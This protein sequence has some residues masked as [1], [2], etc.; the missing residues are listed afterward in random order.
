MRAVARAS[1]ERALL[2]YG[3]AARRPIDSAAILIAS[4]MSLVIL[5]NCLFWQSR[6]LPAPVF[7][8]A[9]LVPLPSEAPSRPAP[10]A[11]APGPAIAA[12][13]TGT[14][15]VPQP[16]AARKNDPIAELIGPSPRIMAV[17]KT[18]SDYGYGQ[19]RPTGVLDEATSSA[20]EKFE[21]DHKMPV[22][23]RVTSR[24]VSAIAAM[25]GRS[26]E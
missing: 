4:M 13:T 1:A 14:T 8:T 21:R 6:P 10:A 25:S 20:I 16:V 24:L 26:I 12:G 18:L 3:K 2:L 7:A 9:K 23:G 19:I 15:P 17:Q 11:L 5:A 22:T